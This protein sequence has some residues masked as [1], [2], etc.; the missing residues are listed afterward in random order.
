VAST[1]VKETTFGEVRQLLLPLY[2][3]ISLKTFVLFPLFPMR[4]STLLVT[5]QNARQLAGMR[6]FTAGARADGVKAIRESKWN[7]GL[8]LNADARPCRSSGR[9][10]VSATDVE[11]EEKKQ[12]DG[13]ADVRR[14]S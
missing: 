12:A 3:L 13:S 2:S 10:F 1:S 5:N 9:G 4:L 6:S 11:A 7:R 8:R 14:M